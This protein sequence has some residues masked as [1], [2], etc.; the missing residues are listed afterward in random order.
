VSIPMYRTHV[1]TPSTTTSMVSP[2]TTLTTVPVS[3]G[4]DGSAPKT[5]AGVGVEAGVARTDGFA[6]AVGRGVDRLVG[7]A[8][9]VGAGATDASAASGEG[10]G[11]PLVS[12]LEPTATEPAEGSNAPAT[13]SRQSPSGSPRRA[14]GPAAVED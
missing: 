3:V 1:S 13:V 2:S 8:V 7:R 12:R 9:A 11:I 4:P 10:A 14:P 6:A 5:G